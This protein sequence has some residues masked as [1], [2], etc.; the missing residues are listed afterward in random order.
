MRGP[1]LGCAYRAI[2]KLIDVG[3]GG[4]YVNGSMGTVL[5]LPCLS[6]GAVVG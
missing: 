5:A 1:V 3:V 4:A 6:V 2:R